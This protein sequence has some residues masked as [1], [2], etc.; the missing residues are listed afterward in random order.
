VKED[1]AK[2]PNN[3]WF[4]CT[5]YVLD[6]DV[7]LEMVI[8]EY[9]VILA[10]SI[11]KWIHLNWGDAGIKR[12]FHRIYKHLMPNGKLILEVQD[13]KTYGKRARGGSDEM[14]QH[15]KDIKLLP[16]QF[17]DFLLN[18]VGFKHAIELG[19]PEGTSKGFSRPLIMY[20]K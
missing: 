18:E 13:I 4:I 17:N 14:K 8:P 16:E 15:Y 2:F 12:F 10:L 3:V 7:M 11:T 5:N 6:S 19:V 20:N 1:A 9:N